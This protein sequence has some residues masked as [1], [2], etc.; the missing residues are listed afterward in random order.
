[1]GSAA[2][3]PPPPKAIHVCLSGDAGQIND[4]LMVVGI[5]FVIITWTPKKGKILSFMAI[6]MG[7]GLLFLHTFG[8]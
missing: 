2:P 3:P 4:L 7:L 8:V 1:M 6:I 5:L